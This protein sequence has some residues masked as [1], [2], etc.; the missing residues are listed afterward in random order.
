[1]RSV[2]F[3]WAIDVKP[4]PLRIPAYRAHICM[5]PGGIYR[6]FL[7]GHLFNQIKFS[8]E[9]FILTSSVNFLFVLIAYRI[10]SLMGVELK[11]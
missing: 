6:A 4:D 1:M 3:V 2:L 8:A 7:P 9:Q 10:E 5:R 11:G